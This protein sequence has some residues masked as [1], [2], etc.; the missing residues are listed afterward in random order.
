MRYT[1]RLLAGLGLIALFILTAMSISACK[2][3]PA[4]PAEAVKL[5]FEAVAA[6]MEKAE[7]QVSGISELIK[8]SDGYEINYHLYLAA[9]QDFDGQIGA[10]L[11]PKIEKLYKTFPALDKVTFSVETPDPSNTARWRPYCSFDMSRQIYN[12][13]NWTNLLARDLFKICKVTYAK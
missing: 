10:D 6:I 4:A 8:T 3:K 11:A 13:T 5:E 12:Q 7:A 1:K 9:Q 2:E